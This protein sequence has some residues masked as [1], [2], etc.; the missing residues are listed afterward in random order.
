MER[1]I[2]LFLNVDC[3]TEFIQ[4]LLINDAR[5]IE[6]YITTAIV[7][8]E[9]NDIADAIEFGKE[10]YETIQTVGKTKNDAE[11]RTT[12]H[13]YAMFRLDQYGGEEAYQCEMI[14]ACKANEKTIVN[15]IYRFT[16]AE[17][18]EYVKAFNVPMNPL[19]AC[20]ITRVGCIG[21]PFGG[22]KQQS[23]QFKRYPQYRKNY[24]RAFELAIKRRKSRKIPW[25]TYEF[26]TGE[27]MMRWWLGENPK[28]VTIEDILGKDKAE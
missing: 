8:G 26:K 25:T 11:Y 20:G 2:N 15:P 21:C 22:P 5:S 19:Y 4:L 1:E 27:E 7:L 9:G 3:Q 6:H 16:D 10:T 28:Q 12:G 23:E 14:K 17:I 24:I 18:W 13:T